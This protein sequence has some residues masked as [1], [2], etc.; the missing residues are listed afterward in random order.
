MPISKKVVSN[1][2]YSLQN[3]EAFTQMELPLEFEIK[4]LD[5]VELSVEN[6]ASLE[7]LF[8]EGI[9]DDKKT[10][11]L[12]GK[13][14]GKMLYLWLISQDKGFENFERKNLVDKGI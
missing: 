2:P 7:K 9:S 13:D 5:K 12:S 11:K 3:L 14:L 8:A 10:L 1:Q 6:R 4:E